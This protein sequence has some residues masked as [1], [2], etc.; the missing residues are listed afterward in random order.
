VFASQAE[1][2]NFVSQPQYI[3]DRWNRYHTR[4]PNR[5]WAG[6]VQRGYPTLG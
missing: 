4:Y 1:Y 5:T 2:N 6:F 3:K